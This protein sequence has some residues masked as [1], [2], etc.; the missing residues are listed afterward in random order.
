M[1]F[2]DDYT[3]WVTGASA[4]SNQDEIQGIINDAL[5]WEKR[6][7]ATFEGEKTTIVHFTRNNNLYD[8]TAFVIKGERVKPKQDVKILGLIMDPKLNYKKH[9]AERASKSLQAAMALRR[10]W[11][12]SLATARQLFGATVALV[13]NYASNV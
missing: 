6:S 1:A 7:E 10:L 9:I 12:I 5:Q 4:R 11:A 13:M 2:V 3:A 8:S